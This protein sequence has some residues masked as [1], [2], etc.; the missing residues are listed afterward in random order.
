MDG[1][2]LVGLVQGR[3][4]ARFGFGSG[5][6]VGGAFGCGP[7]VDAKDEEHILGELLVA[8][9]ER[10]IK[11]RVSEALIYQL[12]LNPVLESM[13]YTVVEV[14]NVYRVSLPK[15]AEELWTSIA[16]NKRRNIKKA[17]EQGVKV[18]H[19]Y[20]LVSFY[21]MLRISGR[22]VG[23]MPSSFSYFHSFLEVFRPYDKVKVFLAVFHGRS[24]AGVFVVVHGD[25]AYALSA[26][27]REEVWHVRPNDMLHWKAM[28]WACDEGLSWY[29]MGGVPEPPPT[30]NSC[31]WG[32]WRWKR[33]WNGQLK[34]L[35]VYHKVYMPK[36][37]KFITSPY[38][39][40]HSTMQGRL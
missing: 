23:F 31:K 12:G 37:K 19:S 32:L 28:E 22:R 4:N 10:A 17:Q 35:Y 20:D 14:S 38:E 3:Y 11:N 6:E 8:L 13:G 40:I 9:E 21:E 2:R 16:H 29:H 15:N 39:R 1:D 18:V 5:M 34:K 25:T 33:E 26:G 24:I 36:I 27:S 30:E 7:V